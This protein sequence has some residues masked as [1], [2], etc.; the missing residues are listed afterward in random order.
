VVALFARTR[1][2]YNERIALIRVNRLGAGTEKEQ[3]ELSFY[4][5]S[6]EYEDKTS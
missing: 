4:V 6:I 1:K 3:K 2:K 5:T